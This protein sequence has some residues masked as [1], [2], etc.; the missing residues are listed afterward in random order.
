MEERI[1][2][3]FVVEACR[4]RYNLVTS[5]SA[6]GWAPF[7]TQGM[8]DYFFETLENI[9]VPADSSPSYIVDNALINGEWGLST[10]WG[11]TKEEAKKKYDEG[12]IEYFEEAGDDAYVVLHF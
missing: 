11:W 1:Y 3:Y 4:E 5:Q 12:E 8:E 6:H 2:G 7:S 9:G 10:D